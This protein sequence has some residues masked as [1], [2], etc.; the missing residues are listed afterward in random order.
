MSLAHPYFSLMA[1]SPFNSFSNVPLN[2]KY[3]KDFSFL[4]PY[5]LPL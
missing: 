3:L 2:W 5:P 4:Y 1:I